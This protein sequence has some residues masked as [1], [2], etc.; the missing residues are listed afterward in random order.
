MHKY[1]NGFTKKK[2]T[3]PLQLSNCQPTHTLRATEMQLKVYTFLGQA[4]IRLDYQVR[5]PFS[6][7]LRDRSLYC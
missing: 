5:L 3:I 7:T 1:G 2:R 6:L 4:N